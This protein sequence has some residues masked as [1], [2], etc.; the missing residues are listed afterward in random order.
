[1]LLG[2]GSSPCS[3]LVN[4]R[5]CRG[6]HSR[7]VPAL[8]A[9]SSICEQPL[10]LPLLHFL[11]LHFPL[12]VISARNLASP[13]SVVFKGLMHPARH[14]P[15][16]HWDG[17]HPSMAG[18][19]LTCCSWCPGPLG[20]HFHFASSSCCSFPDLLQHHLFHWELWT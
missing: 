7:N 4:R 5:R 2:P 19:V 3:L 9:A 6:Q 11:P 8:G 1:M 17:E 16:Q 13:V 18:R 12:G 15:P 20:N 10:A 14:N